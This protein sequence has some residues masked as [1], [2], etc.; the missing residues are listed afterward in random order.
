MQPSLLGKECELE[1]FD[2]SSYISSLN[3]DVLIV[4]V[5]CALNY[6]LS[7]I[8]NGQT[9]N[10]VYLDPLADF[11]NRILEKY[12]PSYPRI[13]F[14][15][16]EVLS[17]LF[18]RNSVSFYHIRNALDHSV[19][20][21]AIIWQAMVTLRRGGILYLNH[22]PNEA[23]HEGY[24]GFHQYNID[25][26][27]SRLIIWNKEERIDV[28]EVLGEYASVTPT[29][30]EEGRIVAVIEKKA[31]IPADHPIIGESS[32]YATNM[33]RTTISFFNSAP[34]SFSYQFKRLF[35]TVG[36][37][38]LRNFSWHTVQKIKRMVVKQRNK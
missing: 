36:H 5:G 10:V 18:A 21:M 26:V 25:C 22:K 38:F 35:F 6:M 23:V 28:A 32:A 27:D 31:D 17:L 29:V 13:T 30:T 37:T 34:R 7:N 8:Y 24:I 4:D 20:P 15:M 2:V 33:L 3:E 16:G 9:Y 14:G 19:S 11:Y 1:N 12:S